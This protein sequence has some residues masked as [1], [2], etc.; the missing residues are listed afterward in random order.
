MCMGILI[1]YKKLSLVTSGY[2]YSRSGLKGV[3]VCVC[4]RAHTRSGLS[5]SLQPLAD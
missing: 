3:Y 5:H 1:F 4:A 2:S